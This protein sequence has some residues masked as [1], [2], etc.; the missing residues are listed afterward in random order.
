M[1]SSGLAERGRWRWDAVAATRAVGL[2]V[3]LVGALIVFGWAVGAIIIPS[4][5]PASP[6]IRL[7]AGACFV[8][9]GS[10]L[11]L[12]VSGRAGAGRVLGAAVA[13]IG[14]LTL[15]EIVARTS[16]GID[17]VAFDD[18]SR[19]VGRMAPNAALGAT[20]LGTALLTVGARRL[21]WQPSELLALAGG[22]IGWLGLIGY[23]A[24]LPALLHV[25]GFLRIALPTAICFVLLGVAITVGPA[26]G[27]LAELVAG[28][29]PAGPLVRRLF[30]AVVLVPPLV[31]VPLRAVHSQGTTI[32]VLIAVVAI[33]FLSIV[34]SFAL[35]LEAAEREAQDRAELLDLAHD[36]V[37]VRDPLTGDIS[38]WNREA[39]EMYGYR[40]DEARGRVTHD[41]LATRFPESLEALD[42]ALLDHGRWDGELEHRRKDGSWLLVSSRQALKRDARGAPVSIIELN[43]DITERKRAERALARSN[44]ELEQFASVASHDLQE[45]LRTIG[46]FAELLARRHESALDE[47]GRRYLD[48]I[49]SGTARMQALIDGMLSYARVG[50]AGLSLELHDSRELVERALGALDGTIASS[51]ASLEIGELPPVVANGTA[52]TQVFQNLLANAVKFSDAAAPAVAITAEREAG[53]WCFAVADNGI[54]ID[55]AQAERVFRMFQRL[56]AEGRYA[57]TG[58][59]LAICKRIVERHGG[60]I[61]CEPR[62]QG[63]TVFRFTLPDAGAGE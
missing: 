8:L 50:Q 62:A 10:G 21:R 4:A 12:A 30:G 14:L 46:G 16:L 15:F 42:A 53:A 51:G 6:A 32:L 41:L 36:A 18:H 37:I 19:S 60:R 29:G 27:R 43:S 9:L 1:R 58:I 25:G 49:M 28:S 13:L 35:S 5:N 57:G 40:A 59:G 3:A 52:L 23:A 11:A 61:W 33:T 38:Y 54:G 2:F 24:D 39:E 17:Q 26:R 34:V 48:F 47:D 31:A 20:V 55:P 22:M 45:P 63:G 44:I 56:H 7:N